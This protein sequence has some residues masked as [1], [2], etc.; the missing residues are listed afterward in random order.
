MFR[1]IGHCARAVPDDGLHHEVIPKRTGPSPH[2]G[3]KKLQELKNLRQALAFI[4][5][6]RKL[7]ADGAQETVA[8]TNGLVDGDSKLRGS[9]VQRRLAADCHAA[10]DVAHPA[11]IAFRPAKARTAKCLIV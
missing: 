9:I 2:L 7:D 8:A 6:F 3:N 4:D 10:I 5:W 11:Q 1:R